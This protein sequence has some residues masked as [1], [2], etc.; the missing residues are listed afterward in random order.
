V[1]PTVLG[2]PPYPVPVD[3][4]HIWRGYRNPA[5]TPADFLGQLGA[6]FIPAA[7]LMQ[8]A[9]GLRG[10]LPGVFSSETLPAGVPEETAL[11]FWDSQAA[12]HASFQTLAER[13]YTLTHYRTYD[14]R[15]SQAGWPVALTSPLVAE[16]PYYLLDGTADWMTGQ[17]FQLLLSVPGG[18]SGLLAPL[19]GWAQQTAG[20]PPRGLQGAYLLV[21]ETYLLWWELWAPG[22]TPSLGPRDD[23][24][25]QGTVVANGPSVPVALTAS[26]DV[27][28]AGITVAAGDLYN[29]QFNRPTASSSPPPSA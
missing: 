20:A 23:L 5:S 10:Y 11:L 24:A 22:S 21:G 14:M 2:N 28:W 19:A 13:V 16:Q 1:S 3:A 7:T 18:T 12:Y 8:P 27:P 25:A 6:T 15:A 29:M 17:A 4:V 26:L 9:I